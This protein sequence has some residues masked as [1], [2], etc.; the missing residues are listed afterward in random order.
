MV[1]IRADLKETLASIFMKIG[2]DFDMPLYENERGDWS[3][4]GE[5]RVPPHYGLPPVADRLL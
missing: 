2:A 1:E 5:Q 3:N 4:A